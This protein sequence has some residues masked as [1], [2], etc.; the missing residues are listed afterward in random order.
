M[1][2]FDT[3]YYCAI[4]YPDEAVTILQH[5]EGASVPVWTREVNKAYPVYYNPA[6]G[7][8]DMTAYSTWKPGLQTAYPEEIHVRPAS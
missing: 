7:M 8:T 3:T 1:A 2:I 4:R 5:A 6:G